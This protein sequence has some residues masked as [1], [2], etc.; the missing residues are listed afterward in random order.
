VLYDAQEQ[1][2]Q[3]LFKVLPDEPGGQSRTRIAY[4]TYSVQIKIKCILVVS[5]NVL[6]FR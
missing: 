1:A 5:V 4:P 3:A 6:C 2:K